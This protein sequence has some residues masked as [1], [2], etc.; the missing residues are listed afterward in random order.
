DKVY[1]TAL[2]NP[3]LPL[4]RFELTDQVTLLERS[5]PCGSAHQLIADVESRLDDVFAYPG[6]QVVHP[7]V[8]A[9][10]LR[11]DPGIVEYQVRQ[12]PSGA[13]VLVVGD[14]ADPAAVGRAIAAELARMG[15]PDPAVAVA[16]VDRLERQATG[17]VRRFRPLEAVGVSRPG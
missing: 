3:T 16:V 13:E 11:R 7:H 8:F 5:C 4:I 14:P 12:V 15:V 9:S 6:G 1:L 17:K 10:V 2:A